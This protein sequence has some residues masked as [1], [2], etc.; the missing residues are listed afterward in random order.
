MS[1]FNVIVGSELYTLV[2]ILEVYFLLS[3]CYENKLSKKSFKSSNK[4]DLTINSP[5]IFSPSDI[6]YQINQ[7]VCYAKSG[8]AI[9][10]SL[11]YSKKLYYS[12][13]HK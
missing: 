8:L 10:T 12:Q 2:L 1:Q 5:Q 3:D 6:L 7:V 13:N 9:V 4:S 11:V